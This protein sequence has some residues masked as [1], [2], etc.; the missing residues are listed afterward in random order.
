VLPLVCEAAQRAYPVPLAERP[1]LA[2]RR[3]SLSFFYTGMPCCRSERGRRLVGAAFGKVARELKDQSLEVC[4]PDQGQPLLVGVP[5]YLAAFVILAMNS[6]D[7]SRY[8][9]A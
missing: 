3:G 4:A 8:G 5:A 7:N 1:D 2:G 6:P 9:S